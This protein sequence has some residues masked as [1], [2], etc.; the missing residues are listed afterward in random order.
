MGRK[1]LPESDRRVRVQL[2]IKKKYLDFLK[3]NEVNISNLL[4]NAV[5]NYQKKHKK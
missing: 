1:Q 3:E 2:R 4:E 5:E